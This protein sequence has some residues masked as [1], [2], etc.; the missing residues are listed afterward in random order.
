MAKTYGGSVT[1]TQISQVPP[2]TSDRELT[3]AMVAYIKELGIPG[4]SFTADIRASASEDFA[5]IAEA[6]PSVFIHLS[7]GFEDERGGYPVHNPKVRFNE[8][9][10]PIGAACF[11]HC[12]MRWLEERS[13]S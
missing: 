4:S 9:V 7:A 8:G 2:L 6:V 10:C 13:K 3:E 1:V 12:A 11:A 5:V